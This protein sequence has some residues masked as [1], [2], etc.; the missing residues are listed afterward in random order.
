MSDKIQAALAGALE[1]TGTK[2]SN[3]AARMMFGE[4]EREKR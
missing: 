4:L 3:E 1:L 2:L